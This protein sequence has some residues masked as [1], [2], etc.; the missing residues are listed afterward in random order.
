MKPYPVL[1]MLG[2]APETRGG[3]AAVV[4]AYRTQ[5]LFRR[6]PVEYVATHGAT[7]AAGL[8]AAGRLAALL[9]R[10]RR[11]VLHVHTA[12]GARFW[13]DAAYMSMAMAARCPVLLHLH[14]GGFERFYDRI[15]TGQAVMRYFLERAA[16]VAVPSQRM[17][18]WIHSV[19]AS[20]RATVLPSPV[21]MAPPAAG[22]RPNLIL[23]LG[24]LHADKGIYDLLDAVSQ[25]RGAV[26]DVRLVCAGAGERV[27]VAQYA[28][29]LGIADAVKFT[30]WVGPSGKRALLESAAVFALPSYAEGMPMSLLE[31]MAA[32]V[33]A[34][35]SP[36]G[37]IPEVLVDGTSGLLAAPG[38]IATLQRHLR[39]L[40]LERTLGERIGAAGR[41][42]VRARF[43][44]ERALPKLEEL[45]AGLGLAHAGTRPAP[46]PASQAG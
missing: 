12:A 5:G 24:R 17:A 40:L 44:A 20:V 31:A 30:G 8:R 36:V 1:L 39:R 37:G 15:G 43:A 10:Y 27:A 25:L 22:A 41:E 4:D 21:V 23:F 34:V 42:T 3:M 7:S 16:C 18:R 11:A 28:E 14:G 33:P 29:H 6:W 35:T 19:S 9:A 13:A 45:Y 2:A 32:G 38:D 46:W 26:P